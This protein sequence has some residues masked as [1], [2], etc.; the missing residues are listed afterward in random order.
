MFPQLPTDELNTRID[1]TFVAAATIPTADE[2]L[3]QQTSLITE[4]RTR[5]QERCFRGWPAAD[6][7][8]SDFHCDPLADAAANAPNAG[9]RLTF[10]SQPGVPLQLDFLHSPN[11]QLTSLEQLELVVAL[12][13]PSAQKSLELAAKSSPSLATAVFIPRPGA[14]LT[15]QGNAA[16]QI[17]IARRF[18]LLGLTIDGM[19]VWDIRRALQLLR[20][21]CPQLK[22]LTVRASEGTEFLVAIAS[23]YE[24]PAQRLVLPNLSPDRDQQ[25]SILNLTRTVP[26]E[27]LPIAAALQT[28][29]VTQ[30]AATSLPLAEA[31]VGASAWQGKSIEFPR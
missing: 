16:K 27:L 14:A 6:T 31:V 26:I 18:Q 1:E 25:P 17:H 2:I 22:T 24:P 12:D 23:L 20:Q 7:V 30:T 11:S 28:P 3:K 10:D 4:L 21:Q 15:W 5:L 19:R 8:S 13:Q 9:T 29:I